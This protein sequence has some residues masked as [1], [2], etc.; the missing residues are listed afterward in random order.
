MDFMCTFASSTEQH[1]L[2]LLASTSGKHLSTLETR[3]PGSSST[4]RT[5]AVV[6][7]S[8]IE[9]KIWRWTYIVY[10]YV[11]YSS[12]PA[13]TS[14]CQGNKARLKLV[15]EQSLKPLKPNLAGFTCCNE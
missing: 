4:L 3:A 8:L 11:V 14:R 2:H 12:W 7:P 5:R 13:S 1:L 6:N 9:M 15:L 10:S